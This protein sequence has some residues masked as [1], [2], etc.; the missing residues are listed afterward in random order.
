MSLTCPVCKTEGITEVPNSPYHNC[1]SCHLWFQAPLPPKVFEAD[2]EKDEHGN[3]K[4]H[5]MGDQEKDINNHLAKWLYKEPMRNV[6]GKCL[7]VGSKYPYL[8]HCLKNLGCNVWGMD[9]IEI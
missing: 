9:G 2:H 4:G 6:P 5:L 8:S 1:P 3:F 7:D